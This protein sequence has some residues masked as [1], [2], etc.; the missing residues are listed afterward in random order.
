[1]G[2]CKPP[3][4]SRDIV[5]ESTLNYTVVRLG[6]FDQGS[7]VI[8]KRFGRNE[9]FGGHDVSHRAIADLVRRALEDEQLYARTSVGNNPGHNKG[10]YAEMNIKEV[11][12]QTGVTATTIRYYE[13]EGLI[14]AIDRN[15]VGVRAT[16]DWII[17]RINFVK[18]MRSRDEY[19][20]A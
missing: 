17:R 4:Q 16:D 13:K 2:C 8:M 9:L 11:S 1:M 18:T 12:H 5:T 14:P 6:W 19:R 10:A 20:S 7:Q 3:S 15:D